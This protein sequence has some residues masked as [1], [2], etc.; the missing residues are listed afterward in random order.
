MVI[1][2]PVKKKHNGVVPIKDIDSKLL[3]KYYKC[4]S[5][6]NGELRSILQKGT[7][8]KVVAHVPN[9]NRLIG[10]MCTVDGHT[11]LYI[12]GIG[13]YGGKLL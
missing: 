13:N 5:A 1:E 4:L 3:K 10:C 12:L 9:G 11:D 8:V 2:G 6:Y 7:P